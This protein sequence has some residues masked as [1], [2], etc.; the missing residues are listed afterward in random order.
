[1]TKF[2]VEATPKVGVATASVMCNSAAMTRGI[3]MKWAKAKPSSASS[4][5]GTMKA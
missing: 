4:S 5:E 2:S 3:T 1:M